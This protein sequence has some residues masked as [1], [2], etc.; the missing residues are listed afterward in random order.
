MVNISLPKRFEI[1]SLFSGIG[2]RFLLYFLSF[3]ILPIMLISFIGY[4]ISKNIVINQNIK[5]LSLQNEL[6]ENLLN[7]V[8]EEA[9]VSISPLNPDNQNFYQLFTP[10]TLRSA[11][12]E[13]L[14]GNDFLKKKIHHH[15]IISTLLLFDK[16]GQIQASSDAFPHP[17]PHN[18]KNGFSDNSIMSNLRDSLPFPG[19][20]LNFV[21]IDSLFQESWKQKYYILAILNKEK[22]I[23][24]FNSYRRRQNLSKFY[25]LNGNHQVLISIGENEKAPQSDT[26]RITIV[27]EQS[28]FVKNEAGERVL[29]VFNPLQDKDLYIV[30]EISQKEALAAILSFRNQSIVGVGLL[31]IVLIILALYVS[32]RIAVPIRQLVYTAQDIGDGFLEAPVKV[33]SDDEIGLLA[34]ELDQMRKKL[35]DYYNNLEQKVQMRSEELKKA[36]F[37]LMHQEKMASLGLLAAGIAHEIGNPLTSISSLTQILK[38]RLKDKTNLEDITN[39]MK[40][41]DRISRIVRELVDF[42]RPSTFQMSPTDINEIARTAVGIVKYDNRSKNIN[43]NLELEE[44]LPTTILVADQLLQV[45]INIL[46]NAVDAMENHGTELTLKTYTRDNHIYIVIKDTGCGIP[47]DQK[48]KIFEPF[49]TTKEVGKGTG[50]GL[51]VSYGIIRNFGGEITLQSQVGRGSTFTIKLPIKSS[52]EEM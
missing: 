39:I 27:P 23:D 29:R 42:S 7:R 17:L 16:Q 11:E 19:M 28:N 44:S 21:I 5:Y 25:I 1:R 49:Y 10:D 36:Q 13:P 48:N 4:Q 52:F 15:P 2:R 8:F 35:L 33:K 14:P 32:L 6:I 41:I 18:S 9:Y 38:R 43:F 3:S 24:L 12:G 46:F 50:L 47:E 45:F 51:S 37:Q 34:K 22:I 26:Q 20:N 31:L 30:S 40:N